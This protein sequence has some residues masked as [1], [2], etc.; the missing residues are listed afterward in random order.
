VL[1][2][3]FVFLAYISPGYC[4]FTGL[5]VAVLGVLA[6]QFILKPRLVKRFL[7]SD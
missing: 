6:Y 2:S 7:K 3:L 5:V 4:L 1:L